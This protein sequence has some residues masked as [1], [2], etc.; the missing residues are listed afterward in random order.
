MLPRAGHIS[1][2][3][4]VIMSITDIN[5]LQWRKLNSYYNMNDHIKDVR[6]MYFLRIKEA[7]K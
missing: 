5:Q 7:L 2:L 6:E 1:S 3:Q 4:C